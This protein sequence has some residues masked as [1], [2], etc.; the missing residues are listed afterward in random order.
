MGFEL[1]LDDLV[2]LLDSAG[3]KGWRL[4]LGLPGTTQKLRAAAALSDARSESPLETLIRLL[5][6]RAGLA[7]ETLQLKMFDRNGRRYA[8]L[9]M[10]WPSVMLALEAD[11]RGVHDEPP[12]LYRDRSRRTFLS[13]GW[14][15]LRFT[16]ADL[17]HRPE[18]IVAQV[19]RAL[20]PVR[21]VMRAS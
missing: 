16:W 21:R 8:R 14:T 20:N 13:G 11:G 7:P 4:D 2:C 3:R 10:A 15:I 12:A 6:V 17:T 1:A 19:R 5:L 9:D 18:S